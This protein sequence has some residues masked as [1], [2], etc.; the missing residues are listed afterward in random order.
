MR[1]AGVDFDLG[2]QV[3]LGKRFFENVLI[4]GRLHIVAGGNR[5]EELCLALCR[6]EMGAIG[7]L[8][9]EPA[10]VK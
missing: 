8:R 1:R 9:D 10:A 2:R 7:H 6:L 3:R 5:D 4:G